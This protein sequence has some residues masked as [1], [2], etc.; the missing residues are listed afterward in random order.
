M[1]RIKDTH[2]TTM[3]HRESIIRIAGYLEAAD[4]NFDVIVKAA[5]F[6]ARYG[7]KVILRS[8]CRPP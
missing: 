6:A 1:N 4:Y 2:N 3:Q 5:E 7:S 8:R